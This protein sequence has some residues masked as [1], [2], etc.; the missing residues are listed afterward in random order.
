MKLPFTPTW[1]KC[2]KQKAGFK[3]FYYVFEKDV[4]KAWRREGFDDL[5]LGRKMA[6]RFYWLIAELN[7][8][9]LDQYFWNSSGDFAGDTI[10]DLQRIR[11]NSAAEILKRSSIKLFSQPAPPRLTNERRDAIEQYYGTHP[12]NDDDDAERLAIMNDKENL[13]TESR[14]LD[15]FQKPIALA[16]VVWMRDNSS[17]FSRIQN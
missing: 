2:A 10:E 1:E 8:G 12:F 11:Q 6:M 3:Q 13:E 17:L 9:G 15:A 5:N 14:E 7:N 16:M 4:D